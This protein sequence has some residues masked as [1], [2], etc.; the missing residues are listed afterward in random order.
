[1]NMNSVKIAKLEK[2]KAL[3]EKYAAVRQELK[4]KGDY[5]GK[6]KIIRKF[7]STDWR[8]WLF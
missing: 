4:E 6:Q 2:Q 8:F 7:L 1:M 5:H 3:V